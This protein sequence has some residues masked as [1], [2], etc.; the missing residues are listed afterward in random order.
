MN[1]LDFKTRKQEGQKIS[2]L[3]CYDYTSA[4][5]IANTTID[6][7]LVGDSSA[8]TMHGYSNTIHANLAML[9][10]HTKAVAKAL[11][12]QFIVADLPFLSFRKSYEKTISAVET[13]VRAGAQAVKLEGIIGN[14]DI[15]SHIIHSGIPV[16][17][18]LGLTP[19]HLHQLGGF[20]KQGRESK[21]AQSI[22][23]AALKLEELGCF[24]LVLEC[25]PHVL[26]SKISQKL[27]I[28]CIGIGA[29]HQV[30]GQV[31]VWQDL[32]G[33]DKDTHLSF[34]KKYLP[35]FDLI[36]SAISKFDKEVKNQTFSLPK[37]EH[38][39]TKELLCS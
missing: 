2:M 15:I 16:M 14:E 33:L 12:S 18:H 28:P 31:L 10:F 8:M 30:D 21:G 24:A 27:S 25:I 1:V 19:Q 3:T 17:G 32:L 37:S 13:L 38:K 26:A 9:E 22:Y 29:G 35:G 5:I 7:V 6:C 34:V 39:K 20:R 36:H 4:K 23:E 11:S